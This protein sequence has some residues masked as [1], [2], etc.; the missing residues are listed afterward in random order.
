MLVNLREWLFYGLWKGC[1]VLRGFVKFRRGFFVIGL[2]RD[3]FKSRYGVGNCFVIVK[4]F[5]F[6]FCMFYMFM[7]FFLIR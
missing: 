3:F 7:V 1:L 5:D 4:Y 6:L 2:G